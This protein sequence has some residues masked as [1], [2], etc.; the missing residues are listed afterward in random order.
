MVAKDLY[1][2]A[3]P[4]DIKRFSSHSIRVGTCVLL[5]NSGKDDDFI[6]LW[7]R[8]KSNTLRLYLRNTTLLVGQHCQAMESLEDPCELAQGSQISVHLV[9]FPKNYNYSHM[10]GKEGRG[11]FLRLKCT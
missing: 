9:I 4:E 6:K 7:L 3:L 11:N 10:D 5:H 1:N 2:L 8:W